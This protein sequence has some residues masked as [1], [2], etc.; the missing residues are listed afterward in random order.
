MTGKIK[1]TTPER[2]A[3]IRTFSN[4]VFHNANDDGTLQSFKA[5]T[6]DATTLSR[7]GA[8]LHR[9]RNR[10]EKSNPTP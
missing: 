2:D 6:R 9:Q 5:F 8:R 3:L 4:A 10:W 7:L 1:L